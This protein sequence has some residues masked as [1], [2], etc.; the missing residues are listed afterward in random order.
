MGPTDKASTINH[1]YISIKLWLLLG[2]KLSDAALEPL[3]ASNVLAFRFWNELW[4]PFERL[5]HV[6][7][8]DTISAEVS[9][10][11]NP[12]ATKYMS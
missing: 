10:S 3:H 9:V 5:L 12:I 4:P 2:K 1:S 6:Y 8:V 11:D 7:D